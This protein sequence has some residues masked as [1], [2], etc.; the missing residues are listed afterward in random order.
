MT[1]TPAVLSWSLLAMNDTKGEIRKRRD[2][3]VC[4]GKDKWIKEGREDQHAI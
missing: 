1:D 2:E 3:R 4:M